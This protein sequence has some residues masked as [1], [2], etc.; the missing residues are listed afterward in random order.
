MLQQHRR[1][2]VATNGYRIKKPIRRCSKPFSSS[3]VQQLSA[4]GAA[5]LASVKQV[6]WTKRRIVVLSEAGISVNAGSELT[7]HSNVR[8]RWRDSSWF[9]NHTEFWSGFPRHI[10]IQFFR[11]HRASSRLGPRFIRILCTGKA[12]SVS[13][14][15]GQ[16]GTEWPSFSAFYT[17]HRLY[18]TQFELL[19]REDCSTSWPD[20][21]SQVSFMQL[22]RSSCASVILR[23]RLT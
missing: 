12:H 21:S 20:R 19:V 9:S 14:F 15:F 23:S 5:K 6:L 17:E 7:P 8:Y 2:T 13:L 11:S 3:L 16:T 22:E 10:H 4:G 1:S 18:W